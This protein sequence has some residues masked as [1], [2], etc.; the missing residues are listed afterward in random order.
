MI[1]ESN[2]SLSTSQLSMQPATAWEQKLDPINWPTMSVERYAALERAY[3]ATVME[4]GNIWWVEIRRRFYRPLLPFQ[5]YSIRCVKNAFHRLAFFQ[6]AVD[7]GEPSNSYLNPLVFSDV[8]DYSWNTL[9]DNVRTHIKK[10]VKANIIV[11]RIVDEAEFREKAYPVY[12]S[13]HSRTKYGFAASRTE[14]DGFS[15]WAHELFQFPEVVVLG[16]FAGEELLCI[17]ISCLVE[18]TLILK[19]LITSDNALKFGAADLVLHYCR[20][21]AREQADINQIFCGT[22]SENSSL[23]RYKLERGAQVLTLPASLHL[24]PIVLCAVK[25]TRPK[26]YSRLCGF[27]ASD[28]RVHNLLPRVRSVSPHL[29]TMGTK[30]QEGTTARFLSLGG[31]EKNN[32]CTGSVL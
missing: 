19:S 23:N 5:R 16:A 8:R 7:E 30:S 25:K 18:N 28:L 11:S 9:R 17:E 1:Q 6:H 14:H 29:S 27:G 22:L 3:G 2:L 20:L 15:K 12:V 31:V 26:I 32:T 13:F 4:M 10:A 21:G 24:H